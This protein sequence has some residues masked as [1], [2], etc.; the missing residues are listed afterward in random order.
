MTSTSTLI[1]QSEPHLKSET[2]T[3][4]KKRKAKVKMPRPRLRPS[5]RAAAPSISISARPTRQ[6]FQVQ[7]SKFEFKNLASRSSPSHLSILTSRL[8]STEGDVGRSHHIG[9]GTFFLA[10]FGYEDISTTGALNCHDHRHF[11]IKPQHH[12]FRKLTSFDCLSRPDYDFFFFSLPP[13]RTHAFRFE[14][15]DYRSP[16]PNQSHQDGS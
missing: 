10:W 6:G 11:Y 14:V 4:S 15:G 9:F 12:K 8:E 13:I 16:K 1:D 5:K 3:K 2:K 7:S